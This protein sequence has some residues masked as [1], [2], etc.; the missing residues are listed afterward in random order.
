VPRHRDPAQGRPAAGWDSVATGAGLLLGAAIDAV[1]ADPRRGHPVAAFG[2]AT[3]WLEG[4]MYADERPRG[5]A[6]AAAATVA[7]LVLGVVAD[8]SSRGG[9]GRR[10]AFTALATWAV[11][12]GTT[13]RR[14]ATRMAEAL[15]AD[16][17]TAGR[18]RLPHLAGRDPAGL[19]ASGLAR[20]TVE[21]VAE[22]TA[23][24]VVGPLVWGALAGIPGLLGYRAVNTLDAMVGH[25][26]S[27]YANFG[28]ASARLDDLANLVP[29]RF[30]AL[31]TV[32]AAPVVGGSRATTL[33]TWWWF[34]GQHPSPNSGQCEASA[35]GALGVR[36]GGRNVYG[37]R[38]ELRPHLGN[39]RAPEAVD[40]RRAARLSGAVTTLAVLL[41]AGHVAARP[42]R[43]RVYAHLRNQVTRA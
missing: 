2:R 22:N 42:L 36:L 7:P 25:R 8:R 29:S 4:R 16:D 23:D 18:A 38:I 6:F 30:T 12:G 17:L 10:V 24:A 31:L 27:R 13:L 21:S 32:L 9:P 34:G 11:L 1:V 14:E 40:V 28:W 15:E 5:S 20:A 19:D 33:R 26:S 35:A 3:S 41:T 37:D 43:R 39:G